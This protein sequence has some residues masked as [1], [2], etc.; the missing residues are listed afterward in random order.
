MRIMLSNA[1]MI[2]C[3]GEM[4]NVELMAWLE[5]VVLVAYWGEENVPTVKYVTGYSIFFM[6]I[7]FMRFFKKVFTFYAYK[8]AYIHVY[9]YLMIKLRYLVCQLLNFD[10]YPLFDM[11][12]FYIFIFRR[13][14][15]MVT[16]HITTARGSW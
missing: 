15:S 9:N 3:Q 14:Q 12:Q 11:L 2:S 13:L 7:Y 10:L 1:S 16:I 6:K 5:A 8:S 4:I